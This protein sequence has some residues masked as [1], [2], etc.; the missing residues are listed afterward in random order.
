M[1]RERA[2]EDRMKKFSNEFLK[3]I[4]TDYCARGNIGNKAKR[5]C[6]VGTM[7]ADHGYQ[8]GSAVS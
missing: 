2:K 1:W 4:N 3:F 7:V 5:K 6:F 8:V